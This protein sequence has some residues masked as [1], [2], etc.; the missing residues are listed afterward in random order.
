[1]AT[2]FIRKT[3]V[4]ALFLLAA[5]TGSGITGC[6]DEPDATAANTV[7]GRW[8]TT[9]QVAQGKDVF[10]A[11][12]VTC[13]GDGAVGD[14]NWRKR[15]ADGLFPPPPLNGSAHAWHHPM[16]WLTST[17]TNG[18][19][20][21]QGRMPAWGEKLSAEDIAATVAWFQ[22]LWPE[23]IYAVWSEGNARY[24]SSSGG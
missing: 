21:G 4:A 1:M 20:G 11:N 19:P 2:A 18:T 23:E 13:H 8:F 12:C 6:S 7:P 5:F 10:A 24:E 22:S 14:P 3:S 17:I 16:A 15:G 9:E